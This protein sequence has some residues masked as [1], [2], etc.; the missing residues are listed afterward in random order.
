MQQPGWIPRELC[1]VKKSQ[2]PNILHDSIYITSLKW[3]KYRNGEQSSGFQ[4]LRRG[5]GQEG[6][7]CGYKRATGGI[8]GNILY[9]YSFNV[10]ILFVMLYY[11]YASYYHWG[12]W[13]K[14]CV[15]CHCIISYN[16][17]CV[18]NYFKLKV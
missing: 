8:L 10:S 6:S 14:R 9:L 7:E 5:W 2:S 17:M 4:R 18:Y 13:G 11:S 12:K 3:Q 15:D 16:C 1:W